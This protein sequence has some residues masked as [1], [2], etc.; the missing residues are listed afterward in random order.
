M[1]NKSIRLAALLL[2]LV[3]MTSC[4][5][6]STFAKYVTEGEGEDT[7][8]VAKF[9]V[10]VEAESDDGAFATTYDSDSNYAGLTVSSSNADKLVA[11]G[12]SGDF[13]ALNISGTPEVAVEVAYVAEV[14]L[15]DA[16]K[17]EDGSFYCPIVITVGTDEFDGADYTSAADFIADIEEAISGYTA[18]YAPGTDLSA[19]A[20]AVAISWAWPFEGDDVKDTYLGDQ[21]ADDN[22]GEITVKV[23]VTV[24]QID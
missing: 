7:A 16:W 23:T 3:L 20:E 10:V 15:S 6:G 18:E 13:A 11:P 17:A 22:A 24:T 14:S 8:R 12:T 19:K 9:G 21:A 1:K 5:V 2:A 4:F